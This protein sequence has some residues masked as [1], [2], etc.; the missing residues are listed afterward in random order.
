MKQ[1]KILLLLKL[2]MCALLINVH[3]FITS[4]A[5]T[6]SS[7]IL[8]Q[9]KDPLSDIHI[10]NEQASWIASVPNMVCPI[11]IIT[12]GM[13][14]DKFGRKKILQ[15]SY[16]PI[17]LGWSLLVYAKSFHYILIA[18]TVLGLSYGCG[19]LVCIYAAE[20]CPTT[21]RPMFLALSNLISGLSMFIASALGKYFNWRIIAAIYG[22]I[23]LCGSIAL[24][25]IPEP[26]L[27]LRSRGRNDEANRAEQWLGVESTS[28]KEDVEITTNP[29]VEPSKVWAL[30]TYTAPNVWKPTVHIIIL[31]LLQQYS[32]IHVLLSYSSDV[33]RGFGIKTD[34]ITISMYLAFARIIG[35]LT[36]FFLSKV[37]RRILTIISGLGTFSALS[38]ITV[39]MY[40]PE[41]IKESVHDNWLIVALFIFVFFNMLAIMP[42]PWSIA[43]EL[44]PMHVKGI[45]NAAVQSVKYELLFVAIKIYPMMVSNVGI[46]TVWTFYT[47]VCLLAAFYG[48]IFMPETTGKTLNEITASFDPKKKTVKIEPFIDY[49]K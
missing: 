22:V 42:I 13:V 47:T 10:N 20:I 33:L 16:L 14:T 31:T 44:Y 46:K 15:I 26:P 11:G 35:N 40:A 4:S 39:Y 17:I 41:N 37:K 12:T 9:L 28:I 49:I 38:A 25:A 48:W 27:W 23:S 30:S 36:Y 45:I 43:G 3:I 29:P 8:A 1:S 21:Y 7:I 32:G 2:L 5:L 18:R 24:F 6:Y 34:W 19:M